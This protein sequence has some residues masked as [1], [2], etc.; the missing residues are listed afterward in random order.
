MQTYVE[1][2]SKNTIIKIPQYI[3]SQLNLKP[4]DTVHLTIRG[5]DLIVSPESVG[6]QTL[7]QLLEGV[8][9][10]NRPEEVDF[11]PPGGIEVW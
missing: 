9:D 2:H 3:A 1:K 6:N 5:R 10:S 4:G 11:G 7:E 8:S